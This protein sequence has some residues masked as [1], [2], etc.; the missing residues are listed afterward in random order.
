MAGAAD[1]YIYAFDWDEPLKQIFRS[2]GDFTI[3]DYDLPA[4]WCKKNCSRCWK[5]TAAPLS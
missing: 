5:N 4:F 1:I 3:I 2:L